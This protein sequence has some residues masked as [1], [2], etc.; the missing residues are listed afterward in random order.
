M[1]RWEGIYGF[2]GCSVL[3]PW[4]GA[5][6]KLRQAEFKG[7]AGVLDSRANL[8]VCLPFGKPSF[9]FPSQIQETEKCSECC[10]RMPGALRQQFGKFDILW[11]FISARIVGRQISLGANVLSPFRVALDWREWS[12]WISDGLQYFAH[13]ALLYSGFYVSQNFAV[14]TE[15][16]AVFTKTH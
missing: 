1:S 6:L 5:V 10:L 11:S 8:S 7:C 2:W 3:V 4:S 16:S 9:R 15:Q 14:F 12:S 13:Q